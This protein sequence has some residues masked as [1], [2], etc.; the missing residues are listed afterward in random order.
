MKP[1]GISTIMFQSENWLIRFGVKRLLVYDTLIRKYAKNY[2]L[3]HAVSFSNFLYL[4]SDKLL[5]ANVFSL[6][7]TMGYTFMLTFPLVKMVFKI[8]YSGHLFGVLSNGIE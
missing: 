4:S 7:C 5:Q 1:A 3:I 2:L 6:K 8:F